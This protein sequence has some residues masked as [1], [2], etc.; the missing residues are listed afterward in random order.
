MSISFGGIMRVSATS[1]KLE[2]ILRGF[3]VGSRARL[4]GTRS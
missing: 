4:A 3:C 1:F 2:D